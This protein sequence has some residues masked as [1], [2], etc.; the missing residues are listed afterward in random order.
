MVLRAPRRAM[1]SGAGIKFQNGPETAACRH[2]G[3]VNY[4]L[5][6]EVRETEE[7]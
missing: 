6:V 4:S 7:R 3:N 2:P 1:F 5:S